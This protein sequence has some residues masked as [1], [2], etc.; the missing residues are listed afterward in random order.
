MRFTTRFLGCGDFVENAVIIAGE[1]ISAIDHHVDHV[2]A[3]VRRAAHFLKFQSQRHQ[4]GWK[5]GRDRCDFDAGIPEKFFREANHVRINANRGAG[6]NL[7]T[8]IE[9][10]HRFA[11]KEGDFSG[12]I[13]S[14]KR[15]QVHHRDRELEPGELGRG[16]YAALGKGASAFLDHDLIDSPETRSGWRR[17]SLAASDLRT[18]KCF[19]SGNFQKGRPILRRTPIHTLKLTANAIMQTFLLFLALANPSPLALMIVGAL[20]LAWLAI[21]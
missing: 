18:R 17:I 19:R 21:W 9:W 2:R 6:R 7:V 10:K 12:R 11:T 3:V 8:R 1:K 15:G 4:P 16:F 13:F 14:F 5:G 20:N